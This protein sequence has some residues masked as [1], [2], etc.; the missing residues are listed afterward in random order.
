MG[1]VFSTVNGL[2]TFGVTLV[3]IALLVSAD[4]KW[5]HY[6]CKDGKITVPTALPTYIPIPFSEEEEEMRRYRRR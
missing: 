3:I 1:I 4:C 2:V 5:T 6:I